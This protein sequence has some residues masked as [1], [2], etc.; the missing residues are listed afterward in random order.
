MTAVFDFIIP[1][2][3]GLSFLAVLYFGLR[4]LF[5]RSRISTQAYGVGQQEVKRKTRIYLWLGVLAFIF[6]LASLAT[7]GINSLLGSREPEPVVETAVPTALIIPT[8]IPTE[9]SIPATPLSSPTSPIPTN[10]PLPSP[11]ATSTPEPPTATV[12]IVAGVW[13]RSVPTLSGEQ[14]ERLF[15]GEVVILL[16][17]I[18]T[19]DDIEWQQIQIESGV[20][21]WVA[22]EYITIDGEG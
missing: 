22:K 10:T 4:A 15:Q 19:A 20:I 17:G 5:S 14:L 9:T 11:T 3:T 12:N 18:E 6:V 13:L 7:I 21:G 8:A 2:C 1:I 16:S